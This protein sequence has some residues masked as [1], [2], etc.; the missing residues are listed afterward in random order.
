MSSP[1]LAFQ[2]FLRLYGFPTSL[3]QTPF[4]LWLAIG[5]CCLPPNTLT[6]RVAASDWEHA[7]LIIGAPLGSSSV[8][9]SGVEE[10]LI[11]PQFCRRRA[12]VPRSPRLHSQ[13]HRLSELKGSLE[14]F[15]Q[16][17][18]RPL[19]SPELASASDCRKM[20]E[21]LSDSKTVSP[22]SSFHLQMPSL[23]T[24]VMLP[25]S[26]LCCV[27]HWGPALQIPFL[28][29]RQPSEGR[30]QTPAPRCL[31]SRTV[32]HFLQLLLVWQAFPTWPLCP[33]C[34]LSS[35]QV[36]EVE[37]NPQPWVCEAAWSPSPPPLVWTK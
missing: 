24:P 26:F 18:I 15:F 35:R 33:P 11:Q 27:H 6:A 30:R 28:S 32:S 19:N 9:L 22:G 12:E 14:S 17:C 23:D 13:T 5:F 7:S 31:C 20:C 29:P 1:H 4:S 36:H 34:I 37:Q 21:H 3:Q 8:N 16:L 10:F 25:E 2:P